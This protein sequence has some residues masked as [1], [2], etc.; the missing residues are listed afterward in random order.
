MSRPRSQPPVLGGYTFKRLLGQG[1]FADVFL[2]EKLHPS[3]EVAVKVLRS[4]RLNAEARRAFE[5]EANLMARVSGHPFI[6]TVYDAATADDGRPYLVM[7]YYSEPHYGTRAAQGPIGVAEV[8]RLGV[9][10]SSAV[11]A[12][13]REGIVHRDIKPANI[14]VNR[15]GR[16]GLTDFGIAGNRAGE[17]ASQG[18]SVPFAPPEILRGE[19][20]GD[21]VSDVY[22]LAATLYTLLA[23]RSPFV[24]TGARTT[25]GEEVAARVLND[26]VP[27]I[28]RVDVP[29][30]LKH[31][32]AQAMSKDPASRPRSALSFARTLQGIQRDCR[33]QVTQIELPE[34]FSHHHGS[35]AGDIDGTSAGPPSGR[36]GAPPTFGITTHDAPTVPPRDLPPPTPAAPVDASGSRPGPGPGSTSGHRRRRTPV[37]AAVVAVVALLIAALVV[38]NRDPDRTVAASSSEQAS[39]GSS[40]ELPASTSTSFPPSTTIAPPPSSVAGASSGPASTLATQPPA[41]TPRPAAGNEAPA[42]SSTT[43]RRP[44]GLSPAQRARKIAFLRASEPGDRFPRLVVMNYDGS[45]QVVL[46]EPQ[47]ASDLEWSPD[48]SKLAY[49]TLSGIVIYSLDG[50][51]TTAVPGEGGSPAWSPDGTRLAFSRSD[52]DRPSVFVMNVDGS[53]VRRVATGGFE[54]AWSPD[55]R[56]IAFSRDATDGGWDIFTVAPD[57][58]GLTRVTS[59]GGFAEGVAWS[60]DGTTLAFRHNTGLAIVGADGKGGRPIVFPPGLPVNPSWFPDS[61]GVAFTLQRHGDDCSIAAVN[62][63]GS[64]YRVLTASPTCDRDP[65]VSPIR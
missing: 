20:A 17:E 2:Y 31:V 54:P 11:E 43:P 26:P 59:L 16:P 45:D 28:E 19:S 56:R 38:A 58:S 49:S 60:P 36:I 53:N 52:G 41:T 44:G 8:L 42:V 1:G 29:P 55:G 9:Q 21:E 15:Y 39:A 7:E 57:G 50:G 18:W 27:P 35:S 47:D 62:R 33:F 48:G 34:S 32:L 64:G 37:A 14:L 24:P 6:V 10:I 3:R 25:T 22:S 51:A 5:A 30:A 65:V 46:A 13:H 12:G 23:G 63:D 4:H 40:G 61:S